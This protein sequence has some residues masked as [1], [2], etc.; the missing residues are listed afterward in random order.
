MERI[1]V[2][3]NYLESRIEEATEFAKY[4]LI[5]LAV[6]FGAAVMAV[7][8]AVKAVNE[9]GKIMAELRRGNDLERRRN[10]G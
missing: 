4:E 9:F 8:E 7:K 2:E 3:M 6:G 10:N 1:S 5:E